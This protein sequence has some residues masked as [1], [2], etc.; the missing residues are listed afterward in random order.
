MFMSQCPPFLFLFFLSFFSLHLSFSPFASVSSS[1]RNALVATTKSTIVVTIAK[2][3]KLLG[4]VFSASSQRRDGEGPIL[5]VISSSLLCVIN[6]NIEKQRLSNFRTINTSF[7]LLL[8]PFKFGINERFERFLLTFEI[9]YKVGSNPNLPLYCF[10]FLSIFQNQKASLTPIQSCQTFFL[11]LFGI[12]GLFFALQLFIHN[13]DFFI[14]PHFSSMLV[15]KQGL[16][17]VGVGYL[18]NNLLKIIH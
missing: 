18:S 11:F 7:N 1:S 14:I 15:T 6:N 8:E 16:V 17:S 12:L 10:F 4:L 5:L 3:G 13:W 9:R 2:S